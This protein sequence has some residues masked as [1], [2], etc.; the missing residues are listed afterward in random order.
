MAHAYTTK[1]GKN[2]KSKLG[3]RKDQQQNQEK[4]L[5]NHVNLSAYLYDGPKESSIGVVGHLTGGGSSSSSSRLEDVKARLQKALMDKCSNPNCTNAQTSSTLSDCS[6]CRSVRYC[7]RDCQLAHWPNHKESCKQIRKELQIKEEQQKLQV[8]QALEEL[9]LQ[10]QQ[11]NQKQAEEEK[12][13]DDDDESEDCNEEE[14]GGEEV[15]I[16]GKI[17]AEATT[18][19]VTSTLTTMPP[20]PPTDTNVDID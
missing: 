3:V 11:P 6:A 14:E 20:K 12:E 18:P 7:C 19:I 17:A 2:K 1:R 10:Q 15:V 8:L 16:M 13:S 9:Q 4:Q 5:K